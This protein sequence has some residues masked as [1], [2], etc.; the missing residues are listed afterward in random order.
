MIEAKKKKKPPTTQIR[1][2]EDAHE[3]FSRFCDT[4]GYVY[5]DKLTIIVREFLKAQKEVV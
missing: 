5:Q 3:E 1:I 2:H 4:N